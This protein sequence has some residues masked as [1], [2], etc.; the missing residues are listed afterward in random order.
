MFHIFR[1]QQKQQISW[2]HITL[3]QRHPSVDISNH[4][5][6]QLLTS[7][8]HMSHPGRDKHITFVINH[9][10]IHYLHILTLTTTIS[11]EGDSG[12]QL[13]YLF[14]AD[15]V[16]TET[17]IADKSDV[18]EVTVCWYLTICRWKSIDILYN[19]SNLIGWYI[20]IQD[21]DR[22]G[23]TWYI[24]SN[25]HLIRHTMNRWSKVTRSKRFLEEENIL[26]KENI[27]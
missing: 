21:Q 13:Q 3:H 7:S 19:C 16:F 27:F 12:V 15:P 14:I 23:S 9:R 4:L 5:L 6:H 1:K 10:S 20:Y 17:H 25:Y 26:E 2:C 24:Y 11:C 22:Y 18:T 8:V